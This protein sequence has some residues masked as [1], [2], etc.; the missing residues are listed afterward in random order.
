MRQHAA[1]RPSVAAQPAPGAVTLRLS[2]PEPAQSL[3]VSRGGAEWTEVPLRAGEALATLR[4]PA[5]YRPG[6]F[7][8]RYADRDGVVSEPVAWRFEPLSVLRDSA[9]RLLDPITPFAAH[10]ARRVRGTALN[11]LAVPGSIRP[12]LQAV[13]WYTDTDRR[14]RIATIALSEEA[15]LRGELP[16][17]AIDMTASPNA[18]ALYLTAIL[19]DGTRTA[20]REVPIR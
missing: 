10:A 16:D 12:A 9:Q 1:R 15:L 19:F 2:L 8:F 7:R 4:L 20:T 13:E 14:P 3:Q 18:R 6:E 5:P 11:A 17:T